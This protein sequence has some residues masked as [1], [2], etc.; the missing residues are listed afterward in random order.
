MSA[1]PILPPLAALVLFAVWAMLLVSTIGLWRLTQALTGTVPKGGF[2]PGAPHGSDAYWRL[3]RAHMN[4]VENLPIF[5]AVVL[6]GVALNVQDALFQTLPTIVILA[7]V[8]QTLIHVSSGAA[9]VVLFRF[10]AY[11]I[12]V[13]AMLTMAFCVLTAAGVQLPGVN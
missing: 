10:T 8:A 12:Q 13:I 9:I 2:V 11:L 3:N 6:S 4:A 7:R 5:G 1:L